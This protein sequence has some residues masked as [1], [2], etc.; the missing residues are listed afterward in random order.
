MIVV[1]GQVGWDQNEVFT[2]LTFPGQAA[3][4]LRN[5][6]A[7]L[8]QADAGPQH[9]VRLTWFIADKQE[10]LSSQAQLGDA[11]REIIGKHYPAMS[12]I[13]VKGFI[14]EGAKLEIEATA[15]IPD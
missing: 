12:V 15:V 11:Y 1:A 14:E 8:A 4:A 13:E 9:L 10:Y 3:Q 7:I 2:D 5:I 6:V